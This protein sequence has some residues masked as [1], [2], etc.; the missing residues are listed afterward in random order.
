VAFYFRLFWAPAVASVCLLATLWVQGALANRAGGF[1]GG[2]F[3]LAV[4]LQA[5]ATTSPLWIAGLVLQTA[6]ALFLILKKQVDR[7]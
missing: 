7:F 6:L 3:L 4:A 5:S 2:W 1:L